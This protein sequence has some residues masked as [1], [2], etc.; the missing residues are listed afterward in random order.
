MKGLTGPE[1]ARL[2]EE[3]VQSR[4]L[5]RTVVSVETPQQVSRRRGRL[6]EAIE[7]NIANVPARRRAVRSRDAI[8][9]ALI[10]AAAAGTLLVGGWSGYGSSF[11][12]FVDS[13]ETAQSIEAPS[14]DHHKALIRFRL[15]E[16]TSE[17][18]LRNEKPL[19]GKPGDSLMTAPGETAQIQFPDG[20]QMRTGPETSL[21]LE[22][23]A[24]HVQQV[25]LDSGNLHVSVPEPGGYARRVSVTTP[26]AK[27]EVKGTVFRV[28]VEGQGR[29]RMTSVS[30]SRGRV[31]VRHEGGTTELGA[32]SF[33]SSRSQGTPEADPKEG[34]TDHG[35]ELDQTRGILEGSLKRSEASR[36]AGSQRETV[37][38]RADL[39]S[40]KDGEKEKARA[41]EGS[42]LSQQNRLL[43]R[44][45]SAE[46]SQDWATALDLLRELSMDFPD[47][48]LSGSVDVARKRIERKFADA[49]ST[50]RS[51]E[52]GTGGASPTEDL[53][54]SSLS[55]AAPGAEGAPLDT[56]LPARN[57]TP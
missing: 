29:E 43:E 31:V 53:H 12:S 16:G 48:P 30:V 8:R 5:L 52:R 21:Q 37:S 50:R 19:N 40:E 4:Q 55:P 14:L 11:S 39:A 20:T 25:H 56:P 28:R 26:H 44:A 51:V 47:S 23:V 2:E 18:D 13:P 45:L 36:V 27:V 33:W 3:A 46:K 38:H 32:G 34:R 15:A 42:T 10:A 41:L 35:N 7:Q 57:E 54:S 17:K 49:E 1:I 24:P 22:T 6:V 9:T